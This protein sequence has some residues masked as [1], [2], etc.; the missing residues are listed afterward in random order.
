MVI[1]TNKALKNSNPTL[2]P[3]TH[4]LLFDDTVGL[5]ETAPDA[6][7]VAVVFEAAA[8]DAEVDP[9]VVAPAPVHVVTVA[10]T[11]TTPPL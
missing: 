11:V 6:P 3:V 4:P 1:D 10:F 9:K 7:E 5:A 8:T 2:G